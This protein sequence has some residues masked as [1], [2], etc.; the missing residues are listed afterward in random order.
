M[1]GV[2]G[3]ALGGERVL[4]IRQPEIRLLDLLVVELHASPVS[5]T[6]LNLMPLSIHGRDC[7]VGAVTDRAVAGMVDRVPDLDLVAL[8]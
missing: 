2:G 5:E 8:V 6:Q 7:C 1:C 4:H 3:V